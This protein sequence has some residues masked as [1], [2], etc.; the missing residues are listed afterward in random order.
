MRRSPFIPLTLLTLAGCTSVAGLLGSHVN[1]YTGKERPIGEVAVLLPES[2]A[3]LALVDGKRVG[4]SV[5]GYPRDVR[6]LPGERDIDID[7]IANS[8]PFRTRFTGIFEA[9]HFYN[10]ECID[11]GKANFT[12]NQKD[13][14]TQDPRAKSE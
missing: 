8:F 12:C 14:G 10:I 11:Q 9:G 4:D 13:L 2:W 5:M 6:V 1:A 7:C 3:Q